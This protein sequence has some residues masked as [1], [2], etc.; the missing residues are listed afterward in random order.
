MIIIPW[1]DYTDAFKSSQNQGVGNLIEGTL[2]S[3]FYLLLRLCFFPG[4]LKITDYGPR[5][6][7]KKHHLPDMPMGYGGCYVLQKMS[8]NVRLVI[9][10]I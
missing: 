2:E 7:W 6:Y 9:V 1:P 10:Q 3:I 5:I 4:H 8:N